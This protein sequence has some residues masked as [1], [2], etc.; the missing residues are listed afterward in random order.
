MQGKKYLY[1]S[2]GSRRECNSN[3]FDE[4]IAQGWWQESAGGR[5]GFSDA[6]D[7]FV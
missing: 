3:S 5:S 1:S 2:M 7:R 4:P 6:D